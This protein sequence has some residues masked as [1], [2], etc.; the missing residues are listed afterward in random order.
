MIRADIFAFCPIYRV[1]LVHVLRDAGITVL[2]SGT[3]QGTGRPS[4][5]S[6]AMI[7]DA[8]TFN[9]GNRLSTVTEVATDTPVLVVNAAPD[10]GADFI[11]DG[12][13]AVISRGEPSDRIVH[14]VRTVVYGVG[15][16]SRVPPAESP[17]AAIR[18][19]PD[20]TL[21]TRES[22]VLGQIARGLTHGQIATRLGISPHTV[23]TYVKRIRTKLGIGNKAELTRFALL[24]ETPQPAPLTA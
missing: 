8:D 3:W 10:A 16:L 11:A 20:L 14:T 5:F 18:P 1:G 4:M 21:S 23:D 13:A 12:A 6:D 17:A 15:V 19:T 7:M 9:D 2:S 24:R 22:Q